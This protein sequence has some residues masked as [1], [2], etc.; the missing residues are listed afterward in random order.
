MRVILL[1]TGG[2]H[3]SEERQTACVFLPE[4]GVV[5]DAGTGFF[6]VAPRL[7]TRE[8]QVFLSHAHL[9][10]VLG[11]TWFQPVFKLGGIDRASVC[12]KPDVL[13]AIQN[14]F[15]ETA[16]FSGRLRFEFVPLPGE[17]TVAEGGRLTHC[18]L[19]NHPGGSTA[20]R[21]DWPR[22]SLAYVTDTV[23]DG[24]YTEFIR[25]VDLLLHEC[26]FPDR[27]AEMADESHHSYASAV[28]ELARKANVGRLILVHLDP[29]LA[30]FYQEIL[31]S[32]R[33]LFPE[34]EL[35]HDMQQIDFQP[36]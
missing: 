22:F 35:G 28:A 34:A 27:L 7:Q 25:D 33:A 5:L 26:T 11:L 6:R 13:A 31:Q 21:I 1:G 17:V 23:V 15:N 36:R 18:P 12:A 14:H 20:Y 19:P 8:L 24:K 29:W 9:D 10:H 2:Y 3:P 4:A 16:I 30:D 32:A